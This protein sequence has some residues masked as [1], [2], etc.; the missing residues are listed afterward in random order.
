MA[1][2]NG[3]STR[4]LERMKFWRAVSAGNELAVIDVCGALADAQ[5]EYFTRTQNDGTSKHFA[6]KFISDNGKQN[7]L[8]WESPEASLGALSGRW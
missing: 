1:L 6:L 2:A 8:Y 7:G 4:L 3:S 5:A